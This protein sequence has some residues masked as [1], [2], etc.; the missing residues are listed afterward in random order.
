MKF[1]SWLSGLV[2]MLMIS[3]CSKKNTD[4][5]DPTDLIKRGRTVYLTACASCHHQDASRDGSIG[6]AIA[7][8]SRE[9]LE[10]RLIYGD[11]PVGYKPKRESRAMVALPHLKNELDALT[12]YLNSF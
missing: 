9:L 8:S 5:N 7:G 3:S 10:R 2:I 6:P 12:A 11:Y 1:V 4:V